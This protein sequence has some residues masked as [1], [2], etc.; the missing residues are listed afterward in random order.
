LT[1]GGSP[2]PGLALDVAGIVRIVRALRGPEHRRGEARLVGAGRGHRGDRPAAAQDGHVVGRGQHFAELVRDQHHAPAS[3]GE[4]TRPDEQLRAL[5]RRQY[6][7]RLVEDE[8]PRVVGERLD[9]LE[10]LLRPH[11]QRVDARVG[12]E[13]ESRTLGHLSRALG[14]NARV[15]ATAP[16]QRDVLGDCHRGDEREVLVHHAEAGGDRVGRRGEAS[17]APVDADDAGVRADHAER[18]SHQRGLPR[19]VLAEQRV[20]RTGA[21]G[22]RRAVEGDGLAEALR[23]AGE[24]EGERRS[25]RRGRTHSPVGAAM[26]VHGTPK[27]SETCAARARTPSVSV[28]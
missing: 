23:D 20:H 25:R 15:V 3:S 6:R 21:H 2:R 26:K 13:R 27:V 4:R 28:A 7:R 14:G 5:R 17:I 8:H 24:L 22:E 16:A 10:P 18:D 19:P 12:V 1:S 11:G 9:D